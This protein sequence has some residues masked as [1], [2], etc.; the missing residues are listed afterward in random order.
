MLEDLYSLVS[1]DAGVEKYINSKARLSL[2]GDYLYPLAGDSTLDAFYNEKPEGEFC[3]ELTEARAVIWNILNKYDLKLMNLAPA[4]FIHFGTTAE[5]MKLM[6]GGYAEY[7]SI[8]WSNKIN[9][10]VSEKAA[11]YNSV[12]SSDSVIGN[13][14]YLEVSFVHDEAR[15]GSNCLISYADISGVTVPDNVVLHGL[16]QTNGKFV[17]RIYG[18][19][20]NPK[21]NLLFGKPLSE[22]GLTA[23][24]NLWNAEIYPECDTIKEAVDSA[25]NLYKLVTGEGGDFE[26]WKK[27]NKKSLCSGFNDADPQAIIDWSNHMQDLVKMYQLVKLIENGTPASEIKNLFKFNELTKIQNEWLEEYIGSLDL[28]NLAGF[29]AAIHLY[30]YLGALLE[31]DD[32]KALCFKTVSDAVLEANKSVLVFDKTARIAADNT[33]VRLPLR[34]NWG[35]GWSDTPPHCIE[36]GGTVLNAAI[37]L[38]GQYP[39]EVTMIK[40]P[41]KKIVFDSRDMDIHGEFTELEPLQDTGNP[42]DPFALQKACLLACGIISFSDSGNELSLSDILDRLGGGFEMHSEVINVPKGSG[43]GTSSIL[44]AACVKAVCDF[45][46]RDYSDDYVYNTVLAMEQIM[47]TGG[48]WQDQ[49]GGLTNGIKLIKSAPGLKQNIGIEYLKISEKVKKELNDRFCL[50]YTGQRRLARNLL[51]DVVGRYVG[52][53]PDSV[54]AHKE[55]QKTAYDMKSALESGDV[56]EFAS[57]LNYHWE[58]S[59][60]IDSGSTNTLIEQILISVD[61]LIDGRFIS[62]AGGGGFLQVILKA[63]V[64]KAD[65]RKRLKSVF[66]DFPV[67]VWDCELV[68]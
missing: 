54:F 42:F 43:L 57:L 41:E 48:G 35:G 55:I 46:G 65:L 14:S 62:G 5:I 36:Q 66:Q 61:D 67:N 25:L 4:K 9:S 12:L 13:G 52:N 15:I 34:V 29:S 7:E 68:F 20:D 26:A 21:G 22:T 40:I 45:L 30:W 50:I 24:E 33:V 1:D 28:N 32:Y 17:C 6:S 39:V 27:A 11:G 8:G 37:K 3:P 59:K 51:R 44:S 23:S 10:S 38:N 64:S 31:N 47:S 19:N 18:I 60:K 63:G 49:T 16:K 58:L 56:D 2:Y 53:E